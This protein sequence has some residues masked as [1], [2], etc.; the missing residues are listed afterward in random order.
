MDRHPHILNAASSLLGIALVIITG[1]NVSN[2]ARTSFADEIAW[3]SAVCLAASC[4]LSYLGISR[5]GADR[6][7][8]RWAD[9]IF[10]AGLVTLFLSVIVLAAHSA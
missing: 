5:G 6:R 2:V 10:L 9:R 4:L 7:L 8:E 3:V 1:L